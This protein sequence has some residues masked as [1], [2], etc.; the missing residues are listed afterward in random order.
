MNR[1]NK[2]VCSILSLPDLLCLFVEVS[3]V[4]LEKSVFSRLV[5][6]NEDSAALVLQREAQRADLTALGT[7]TSSERGCVLWKLDLG[8]S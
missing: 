5:A 8:S 2:G 4:Y 7:S 6:F 3:S 1:M